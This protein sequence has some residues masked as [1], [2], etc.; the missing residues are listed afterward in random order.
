MPV[1]KGDKECAAGQRSAKLRIAYDKETKF[2]KQVRK[3]FTN[4]ILDELC[5]R[6]FEQI[7]IAELCKAADYP[8]ST[9][10]KYYYD[11]QDLLTDYLLELWEKSP[12]REEDTLP[13][14]YDKIDALLR[15]N[16]VLD[17]IVRVNR[18]CPVF[19]ETMASFL[20]DRLRKLIHRPDHPLFS[21]APVE[22]AGDYVLLVI[23]LFVKY[24]GSISHRA[25]VNLAAHLL[26]EVSGENVPENTPI[27]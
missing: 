11:K 18:D 20:M 22:M 16:A 4:A 1:T 19:R 3:D 14:V 23:D 10:Y 25:S 6:T 12:I 21:E 15:A 17:N 26:Q 7:T 9:F 2:I 8:R 13:V 27:H 5:N 24:R